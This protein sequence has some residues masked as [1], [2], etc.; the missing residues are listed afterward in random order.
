MSSNY[1]PRLFYF[2]L[3]AAVWAVALLYAGAYTTSIQAGMAFLDWPLSNSSINPEGWLTQEDMRAEHGHRLLGFSFGLIAIILIFWTQRKEPRR[4]V[5]RLAIAFFLLVL[6]QGILGGMRVLFDQLNTGASHNLLGQTL[7]VLHALGAQLTVC[8][9]TTL[10]VA[11]S[12]TWY[13]FPSPERTDPPAVKKLHWWGGVA[14]IIL[15]LQIIL[16]AVV[17]HAEAGMAIPTFPLTPEGSLLPAHWN[18]QIGIHW[19]HRFG[20]LVT[21]V[22]LALFLGKTLK[23][24]PLRKEL[25]KWVV[26]IAAILI[27]QISLGAA[28]IWTYKNPVM[29]SSHMLVGALLLTT[30]WGLTFMT[31]RYSFAANYDRA[32]CSVKTK[33][34]SPLIAH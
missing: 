8:L 7:C 23:V 10:T 18:F 3:F 15:F 33:N 29:A 4:W 5:R 20:A 34:M 26:C 17:R 16:G 1:Q 32:S 25:G 28:T 11:T 30:T 31:G 22:A 2:C 21:T 19:L 9:L 12:K 24:P 27:L 13:Q 6:A 14:S